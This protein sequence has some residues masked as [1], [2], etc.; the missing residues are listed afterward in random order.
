MIAKL[1]LINPSQFG[2]RVEF[3]H[4]A[5]YPHLIARRHIDFE[6]IVQHK[7]ALG[8]G[9][10]IVVVGGLFLHKEAAQLGFNILEVA[11]NNAFDCHGFILAG[12]GRACALDG[13][14]QGGRCAT[15]WSGTGSRNVRGGN[16]FD[17][18]DGFRQRR[19]HGKQFIII[20]Q[21]KENEIERA[22]V[23]HTVAGGKG[24]DF[25]RIDGNGVGGLKGAQLYGQIAVGRRT[26]GEE[27]F[28][29]GHAAGDWV[30]GQDGVIV[31]QQQRDHQIGQGL[32]AH[33]P[34]RENDLGALAAGRID[35][36]LINEQGLRQ[37]CALGG[38]G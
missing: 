32:V 3:M 14:D 13:V 36:D 29:I 27:A 4:L 17:W 25:A 6:T 11:D 34:I 20:R 33:A 5:A 30:G 23:T 21:G 24:A 7:D 19:A 2:H 28:G 37:R 31:T 22:T 1:H 26:Q 12:A 9:R 35:N 15:S 18:G 8:R 10:V 16:S 38:D